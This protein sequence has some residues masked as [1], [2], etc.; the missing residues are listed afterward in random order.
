VAG[1]KSHRDATRRGR[2]FGPVQPVAGLVSYPR[3]L[4]A[5]RTLPSHLRREPLTAWRRACFDAAESG[6]LETAVGDRFCW[7]SSSAQASK[8]LDGSGDLG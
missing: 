6:G 3:G 2:G 8:H 4:G 5:R 7:Q 1:L